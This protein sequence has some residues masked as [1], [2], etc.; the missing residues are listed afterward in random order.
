MWSRCLV[1]DIHQWWYQHDCHEHSQRC[2]LINIFRPEQYGRYLAN[3]ILNVKETVCI[4]IKISPKFVPGS[5]IGNKSSLVRVMVWRL[6][7]DKP[8]PEPMLTNGNPSQFN[9]FCPEIR[10]HYCLSPRHLLDR[11]VCGG[12]KLLLFM[13]VWKSLCYFFSV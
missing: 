13:C 6:R 3:S 12:S 2:L 8:L 7:G 9:K 11:K 1:A 10:W 5:A 4:F